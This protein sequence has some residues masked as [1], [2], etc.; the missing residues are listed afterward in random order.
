[1]RSRLPNA[2]SIL[3]CLAAV[4]YLFSGHVSLEKLTQPRIS[5]LLPER[6]LELLVFA[7][8]GFADNAVYS[9]VAPPRVGWNLRRVGSWVGGD[10]SVGKAE[11]AWFPPIAHFNLQV[12][13]Y[14][15]SHGCQLYIEAQTKRGLLKRI[16]V[17]GDDP[18]E[19]WQ[20]R[21]ISLP[22]D[23]G[24]TRFRIVAIDNSTHASGWVGFSEP[25]RFI[26][27][28]VELWRELAQIVLS[29][30][31]AAAAL[32]AIL[33]PGLWLRRRSIRLG[34]PPMEFLWIPLPGFAILAV[35]GLLCWIG[36]SWLGGHRIAQLFLGPLF[37]YALYHSFRFP[38]STFTTQLERHILLV[39]LLLTS[40]G[41]SK[42]AYSV[43]PE[44]E[45]FG[46]WI[47]RT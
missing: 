28:R 29:A 4:L 45:L 35:V 1:M 34:R 24:I 41:V 30:L 22:A 27:D 8:E 5:V 10:F 44:G 46:G 43:G 25:F 2:A 15:N 13:G 23:S 20:V 17:P 40:L 14:P 38:L 21:E 19:S 31:T 3:L 7:A 16:S 11:S 12:A 36:P 26:H 47:S 9:G 18:L 32:V 39:V 37:V 6:G 33:F 42:A